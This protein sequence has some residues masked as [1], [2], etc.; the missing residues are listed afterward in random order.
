MIRGWAAIEK[1]ICVAILALPQ[2]NAR[3]PRVS[4]SAVPQLIARLAKN[5][6]LVGFKWWCC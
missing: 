6:I 3:A 1:L 2:G 5:G 4:F